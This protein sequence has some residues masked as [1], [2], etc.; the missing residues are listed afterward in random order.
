MSEFKNLDKLAEDMESGKVA[1]QNIL[2]WVL[3][4]LAIF[5]LVVAIWLVIQI[6]GGLS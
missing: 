6:V 3:A 2:G 4:I 5:S 1:N